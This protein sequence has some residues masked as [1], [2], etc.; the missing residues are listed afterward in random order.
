MP[1]PSRTDVG[2]HLGGLSPASLRLR[3]VHAARFSNAVSCPRPAGLRLLPTRSGG[4]SRLEV[5]A[6][7]FGSHLGTEVVSRRWGDEVGALRDRWFA[8]WL[9]W[10]VSRLG[11]ATTI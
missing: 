9:L 5:V 2:C 4:C 8:W 3:P 10:G 6:S 11:S 7:D 1:T